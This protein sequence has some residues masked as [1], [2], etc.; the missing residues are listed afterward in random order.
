MAKN[1][2]TSTTPTHQ[3]LAATANP[4]PISNDPRYSGFRVYAYGP[5]VASASFLRTCPDASAR[6]RSPGTSPTAPN[7]M[8][9]HEG[10]A[11]QKYSTA[12]TNPNG[13]RM[14]RATRDHS[15][16]STFR[17]AARQQTVRRTHDCLHADLQQ[18]LV[19]FRLA[20]VRR[21]ARRIAQRSE[22]HTSEL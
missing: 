9:R 14:R 19:G 22:E 4:I 12:N 18:S 2:T 15:A 11:S 21:R 1:I 6:I 7:A 16:M 8:D 3:L 10:R 17:C 13:T 20:R 5:E